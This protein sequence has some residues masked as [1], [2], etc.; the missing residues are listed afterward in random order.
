YGIRDQ[1]RFVWIGSVSKRQPHLGAATEATREA[2]ARCD[3][4]NLLAAL[5][6]EP[7]LNLVNPSA[8]ARRRVA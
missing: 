6:G 5:A 8:W 1:P 7:P 2:M 3:V 4:D